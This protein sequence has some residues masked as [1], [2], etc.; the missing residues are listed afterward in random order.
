[1]IPQA[2]TMDHPKRMQPRLL[3]LLLLLHNNRSSHHTVHL[4]ILRPVQLQQAHRLCTTAE[5][6]FRTTITIPQPP[7]T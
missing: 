5:C 2:T 6:C 3:L 4:T 7:P 1:M